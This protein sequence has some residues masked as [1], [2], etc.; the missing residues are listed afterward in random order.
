MEF[1]NIP[2]AESTCYVL[3]HSDLS[4]MSACARCLRTTSCVTRQPCETPARRD[5]QGLLH[6]LS[7]R[8]AKA[9]STSS[10]SDS[11]VTEAAPLWPQLICRVGIP[12]QVV[13][14]RAPRRTLAEVL[15]ASS[16]AKALC[17]AMLQD[18]VT[19]WR[20]YPRSQTRCCFMLMLYL[21]C[22]FLVHVKR[23][24]IPT[25]ITS[26]NCTMACVFA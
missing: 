22:A 20:C 2:D 21:C 4:C 16:A 17:D 10:N 3:I 7:Q 9:A 18:R 24:R 19:P 5:L 26:S 6:A 1:A 23:E 11:K 25:P 14:Q 15:V 12:T 13:E 8:D